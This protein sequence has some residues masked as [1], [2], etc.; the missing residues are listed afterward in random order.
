M[1]AI[2]ISHSHHRPKHNGARQDMA[3]TWARAGCVVLMPD[4][5]GHGE[6]RQHPFGD[7]EGH[8]YHFRYDAGIELHLV[9]ESLMGWMVWDLLRG[10]D[11][12]LVRA[13]VDPERIVLISEPAG[14]GDVAAVTAALDK[15]ITAVMVQNFGGPEPETPYPLPAD[16]GE[17]FDYTGGG[18]W[19]STRNLRLSA[20]DGFLPWTIVASIAPRRLI[21]YHEFYWDRTHDPVWNRLQQIFAFYGAEDSLTGLAGHGFVV[22]S[23]PENTHW[24]AESRELLYPIFERWFRIAS[25]GQEFSQRRPE[26]ELHCLTPQARRELLPKSL[27]D[28]LK[29]QASQ[30]IENARSEYERRSPEEART[31]LKKVWSDLLGN[32][33]ATRPAILKEGPRSGDK[34]GSVTVERL[35]LETEP[36]ILVPT[37]LLLPPRAAWQKLPV[38]FGV[39]QGG[40]EALLKHRSE[41]IADL[42]TAGIAIC[43]PDVRGTGETRPDDGRDRR[44]TATSLSSSEW[45]LGRSLLGSRLADL[46]SVLG[47]L[48]GRPDLD[49][50]RIGLWGDSFAPINPPETDFAVPHTA[51]SRPA[52]SEP[53]GG[54]LALLGALY[55]DDVRVVCVRGGLTDY[56]SVLQSPFCYVPHDVVVPGVLAH[57]DLVD[58]AAALVPRPVRLEGMVDGH[59]RAAS[60]EDLAAAYEPARR[61][62]LKQKAEPQLQLLPLQNSTASAAAWLQAQLGWDG[63]R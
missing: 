11:V 52:Q 36:G 34:I 1:P 17:S 2:V 5:L 19:E 24:L 32:V 31:L 6:R 14:G 28:I 21:Y 15:R 39:A 60:A 13:D 63:R 40:K 48:C 29:V 16:A 56:Q 38:V 27:H 30:Q 20:R 8:D 3:M 45:M 62:Y 46:R 37:L 59:N 35:H 22:G 12:L 44:S 53:L 4:H 49:R 25:P 50:Q 23:A 41:M 58:V 42:L 54:L 51:A 26:E 18:S 33:A 57:G 47:Y 10:V 43:L 61:A 55:E 7:G 9:G